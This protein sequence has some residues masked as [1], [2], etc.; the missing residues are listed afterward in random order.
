MAQQTNVYQVNPVGMAGDLANKS[1]ANPIN[2]T[3]A[4][5][6]NGNAITGNFV[7]TASAPSGT[8]VNSFEQYVNQSGSIVKGFVYRAQD[9]TILSN[10]GYTLNIESGKPCPVAI[11][12]AFFAKCKTSA[13]V[14]NKVLASE[15]DG[16]ISAGAAAVSA[17]SGTLEF[18]TISAYTSWT[19]TTAGVLVLKVDGVQYTL[20]A[21]NFSAATS[22]T[23]VASIINTAMGAIGTC[24]VNTATTGLLFTS[25]TSGSTS[26]VEYVATI[27]DIGTLLGVA[28]PS[29]M[30]AISGTP[31]LIDTG[32]VANTAGSANDIIIIERY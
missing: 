15:D 18:T 10:S 21:L 2:A 28:T 17:T 30:V 13:V 31:A 24:V 23:D 3:P 22:L 11:R 1:Y 29:N 19:S 32:F 7:F 14:G 8:K 27:G 9:G 6:V 16:S 4:C 12:G 26:K 25:A 5:R 20:S